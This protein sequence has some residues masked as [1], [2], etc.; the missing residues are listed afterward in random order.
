MHNFR[1]PTA[2]FRME[3]VPAS[4]GEAGTEAYARDRSN[5]TVGFAVA[6]KMW[7]SSLLHFP[8]LCSTCLGSPDILLLGS[9]QVGPLRVT[10]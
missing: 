10:D 6:G 5:S 8:Q 9:P 2:S 4:D 1:V 7:H 3:Q